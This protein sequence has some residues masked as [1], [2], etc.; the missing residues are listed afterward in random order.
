MIIKK[1]LTW[2]WRFSLFKLGLPAVVGNKLITSICALTFIGL[3]SAPPYGHLCFS[4]IEM[5]R[6]GEWLTFLLEVSFIWIPVVRLAFAV[7]QVMLPWHPEYSRNSYISITS[8]ILT[9]G[10]TLLVG[11]VLPRLQKRLETEKRDHAGTGLSGSGG[12]KVVCC[13]KIF[14]IYFKIALFFPVCSSVFHEEHL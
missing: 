3:S 4:S 10:L 12:T 9:A 7:V 6:F 11:D 2:Y 1:C 13:V 8:S 5:D 14:I